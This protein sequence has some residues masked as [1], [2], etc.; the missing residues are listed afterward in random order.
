MIQKLRE[1]LVRR[2]RCLLTAAG[3]ATDLDGNAL[4]WS[5]LC[6]TRS[7]SFI[8]QPSV[9]DHSTRVYRSRGN[10]IVLVPSLV[11]VLVGSLCQKW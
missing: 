6:R 9:H 5:T 7:S 2:N 8:V 11:V 10:A 1:E 3:L 4:D